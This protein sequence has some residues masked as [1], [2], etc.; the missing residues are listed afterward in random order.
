MIMDFYLKKLD[1]IVKDAFTSLLS[2]LN[3]A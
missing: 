3:W 1:E 2:L